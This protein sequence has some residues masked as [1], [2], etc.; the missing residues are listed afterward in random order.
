[1]QRCFRQEAIAFDLA[2]DIPE[3]TAQSQGVLARY[4]RGIIM[5]EQDTVGGLGM[6]RFG[7]PAQCTGCS[8]SGLELS[9]RGCLG[10]PL[11]K[12]AFEQDL[13][14]EHFAAKREVISGDGERLKAQQRCALGIALTL[15][16]LD[17]LAHQ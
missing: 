6:Q 16:L 17:L 11:A 15:T 9:D 1:M 5:A 4:A 12:R 7:L 2:R 10:L 3:L 8:S 14:P 13:T